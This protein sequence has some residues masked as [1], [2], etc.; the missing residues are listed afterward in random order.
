MGN[1]A[2]YHG[3]NYDMLAFDETEQVSVEYV[4]DYLAHTMQKSL[5]WQWYIAKLQP[6]S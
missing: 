4:D 3:M 2:E 5:M 1:I 6:V